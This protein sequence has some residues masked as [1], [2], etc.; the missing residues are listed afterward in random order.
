M[1]L[2][3]LKIGC[4]GGGA[5]A[6]AILG[7]LAR[8]GAVPAGDLFVTDVRRER[9]E[10]LHSTLEVY[11][12]QDNG[13]VA[14]AADIILVAVKPQ[15]VGAVL[16]EIAV[17]VKPAQTIISIAAGIKT[18]MLEEYLNSPAAVVRV[19]PNTPALVGA[20]A[21]AV[22]PGSH[23]GPADLQRALAIFN[24]VGRAVEVPESVMDAVT[25]LSGSGPA[26]MFVILEALADA[27]VRVGLPRDVATMLAAQTMLG[28][29]KMLLETGGHP[30]R[31]KDMV[32]TPGGTTIE[33][34]YALEQEGLRGALMRAVEA[35]TRR[36][37]EMAG[38]LK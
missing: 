6:E 16:R 11:A 22:C 38:G 5:M 9:L 29:A 27:G 13:Y 25:G 14:G 23:A 8:S 10:Y 15:V 4:I 18:A 34:I 26:Y 2:S 33:G 17:Y 31:M 19:M 30:A 28:S 1:P 36:S 20:G 12:T 21:S 35:A 24:A 7:G 3:G 32:T 37:R